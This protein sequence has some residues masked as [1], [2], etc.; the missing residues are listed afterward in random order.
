M[1]PQNEWYTWIAFGKHSTYYLISAMDGLTQ[2]TVFFSHHGHCVCSGKD[3]MLFFH[4]IG[5]A[6]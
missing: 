3:H 6:N 1:F 4:G 5:D 2:I